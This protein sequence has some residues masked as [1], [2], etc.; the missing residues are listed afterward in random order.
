MCAQ[1]IIL[2]PAME[3]TVACH[4]GACLQS[5]VTVELVKEVVQP[6]RLGQ[7]FGQ[8]GFANAG[9]PCDTV[10]DT[11]TDTVADTVIDTTMHMEHQRLDMALYSYLES[12]PNRRVPVEIWLREAL[13]PEGRRQKAKDSLVVVQ[14]WPGVFCWHATLHV[15]S[16]YACSPAKSANKRPS[17]TSSWPR[18]L[19][20][21]LPLMS[22]TIST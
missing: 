22:A 5:C 9:W 3:S 8:H 19:A 6:G 17:L 2:V 15:P 7:H 10:T 1:C 20:S 13:I 4:E 16:T 12:T 21:I 11:V 14:M 18:M